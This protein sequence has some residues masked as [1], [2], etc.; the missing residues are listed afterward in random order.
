MQSFIPSTSPAKVRGLSP[1]KRGFTY[2]PLEDNFIEI[3]E[4]AG[5]SDVTREAIFN[6]WAHEDS[7]EDSGFDDSVH[8][9]SVRYPLVPLLPR[10]S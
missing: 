4:S 9:T 10:F 5:L 6:V 7:Y 3:P 1:S 8:H 2:E